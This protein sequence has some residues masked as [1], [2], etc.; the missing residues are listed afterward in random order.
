MATF[1]A[2]SLRAYRSACSL[3]VRA[4]AARTFGPLFVVFSALMLALGAVLLY[5]EFTHPMT[6]DAGQVLIGSVC[7]GF[8]FL[9]VFSGLGKPLGING[10]K[11]SAESMHGEWRAGTFL[12]ECAGDAVHA[13]R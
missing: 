4:G 7:L 13:R 12:P 1:S 2:A 11:I 5:D 8:C 9:A 10:H 3:R 6:A